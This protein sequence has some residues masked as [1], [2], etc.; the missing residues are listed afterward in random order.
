MNAPQ[1][2]PTHQWFA[3]KDLP[4][5]D[6]VGNKLPF[7]IDATAHLAKLSPEILEVGS[8]EGRSAVAFLEMMPT[9]RLTA[10][11]IFEAPAVE[12]CFDRNMAHYPGRVTKLKG[13][14]AV[15]MDSLYAARREFDVIYLDAGKVR[16][17]TLAQSA[18]AWGMLKVGGILIWDD[19]TWKKDEVADKKRPEAAI[20]L[21]SSAFASAVAVLRSASSQMIVRKTAEW[22]LQ[23]AAAQRAGRRVRLPGLP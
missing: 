5:P 16:E 11:D 1:T 6:W 22:P 10:I 18:L 12:S 13:R 8:Y 17:G 21:F 7:W 23:S 3:D 20:R 19:L 2:A 4:G 15:H 14:A 9:G